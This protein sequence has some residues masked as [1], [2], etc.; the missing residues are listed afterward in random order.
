MAQ[1][2]LSETIKCLLVGYERPDFLIGSG[3]GPGIREA[4]NRGAAEA[5]GQAVGHG[6]TLP[7][8]QLPNPY[9]T[10]ELNFNF[11]YFIMH[12]YWFAYLGKALVA[13]PGG[14][15]TLDELF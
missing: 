14:F 13:F 2:T 15:G 11:H 1:K 9:I 3:G 8:Q 7:M 4:A 12:K 5:N 6:R 10:D